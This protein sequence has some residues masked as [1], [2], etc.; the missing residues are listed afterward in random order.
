MDASR[1]TTSFEIRPEG[2]FS[3]ATSTAFLEDFEPAAYERAR[4]GHLHLAF[5]IDGTEW[6]IGACVRDDIGNGT[7]ILVDVYGDANGLQ[8]TIHAQVARI[9][10]LDIDGTGF[11]E[12]GERDPVIHDLQR[13]YPG[14]RPVGFFSPYEAAAWA[15]IGN[16]I[17]IAQAARVKA[18][19]AEHLGQDV[20][21]HGD[22]R[23]A[24]PGPAALT[25]LDTFS[26]LSQRKVDYLRH[27]GAAAG[28]GHLDPFDLRSRPTAEALD[29]LK[30]L[31]GIGDFSAE[32]ILLRGACIPDGLPRHEPRLARA[33][34]DAYGREGPL[35]QAELERIADAWRPYRTWV[36]VLLRTHLESRTHEIA[37]GRRAT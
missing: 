6:A 27:L 20:D 15:L 30:A 32:L 9:L 7:R 19:L 5:L 23:H 11:S 4:D 36:S 33:V 1:P 3:L 35:D 22:R 24:F 31:P 37:T 13:V 21:I 28:A 10:S 12:I 2:P 8:E 29:H 26:G 14:L 17:R 34:A 16:R 25:S 18:R